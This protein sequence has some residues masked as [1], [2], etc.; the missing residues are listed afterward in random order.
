MNQVQVKINDQL[1]DITTYPE[2]KGKVSVGENDYNIELIRD[3]GN[4]VRSYLVNNKVV[5]VQADETEP[6]NFRILHNNFEYQTEI[7]TKT[8]VMLEKFL[9]TSGDSA[10]S[11][12]IKAPM[13]GLV[14][15]INVA[16]GD[17]VAKD[18][19]IIIIEAMKMENA[20]ATPV[21]GKVKAIKVKEGQ[22]VN[23][24]DALIE[25]EE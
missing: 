24:N 14:V 13:P 4:N 23:K 9:K 18:D 16:V 5:T 22:A 15:K 8:R 17:E 10:G 11:G 12:L 6:D 1:F 20:L 19:K 3:Y 25:I 7:K 2:Q 21:A